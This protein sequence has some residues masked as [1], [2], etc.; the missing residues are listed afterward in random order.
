MTIGY[1]PQAFSHV[2]LEA[3]VRGQWIPL[4]PIMADKPVGWQAPNPAIRKAFPINRAEGFDP[5]AESLDGLGALLSTWFGPV[6][7]AVDTDQLSELAEDRSLLWQR[8][9]DAGFLS[10]SEK[11]EMLGFPAER[12]AA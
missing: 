8:V 6:A 5:G 11:R 7:F 3:N 10:E 1:T 2:Y 9:N 4:D 12:P